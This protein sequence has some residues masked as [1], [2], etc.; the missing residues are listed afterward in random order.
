MGEGALPFGVQ[1]PENALTIDGAR[2]IGLEL[3]ELAAASGRR[4][5]HVVVQVG[6][7]ALAAAT[8]AGLDDAWRAGAIAARP[9][10]HAVQTDGAAPLA[11]AGAVIAA[12]ASRLGLGSAMAWAVRHRDD[13][14]WSW[15]RTPRSVAGGLLDDETYDWAAVVDGVLSTGGTFPVLD[16]AALLAGRDR[17]RA[18]GID[19]SATGA[20][21]LAAV[22]LVGA[23]TGETVA[24]LATGSAQPG[25]GAGS[26][27]VGRPAVTSP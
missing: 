16:D 13:V 2:T 24:V 27:T 20:A 11:R 21:G 12:R 14:M 25:G 7:G 4:L 6:G 17:C 1:G 9:R 3:A 8:M 10:Y 5:D 15:E 23:G 22:G 18:A 26:R 19:A